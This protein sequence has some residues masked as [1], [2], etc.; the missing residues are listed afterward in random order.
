M[1][2]AQYVQAYWFQ[3]VQSTS[4]IITLLV[5]LA[6]LNRQM[7]Q[8][9]V[10]NSLVVTQH[11]RDL[12]KLSITED[13]LGRVFDVSA[14]CASQP[15]TEQEKM[16]VNM[17]FLHMCATYKAMRAGAIYPVD[18]MAEDLID[19]LSHP[20]PASV[21]EEMRPFHDKVF[22]RFVDRHAPQFAGSG[23]V[24]IL[25]KSTRA[26]ESGDLAHK[27]D[28]PSV[29]V[30]LPGPTGTSV[31]F[32]LGLS[33]P[34]PLPKRSRQARAKQSKQSDAPIK[35]GSQHSSQGAMKKP[36]DTSVSAP[37]NRDK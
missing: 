22:V 35:A 14:D 37:Q 23:S 18:G 34:P 36:A 13:C 15:P 32:E 28:G 5:T 12:W 1:E 11:H 29:T 26:E 8:T 2:P 16:F 33:V 10:T 3:L 31:I 7:R 4:I 25:V 24:P 20:I 30:D 9:K 6:T 17:L 27:Q 21:W 19:M